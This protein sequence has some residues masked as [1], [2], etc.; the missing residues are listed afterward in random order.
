MLTCIMCILFLVNFISL[1]SFR[2]AYSLFIAL[3]P[4]TH[5]ISFFKTCQVFFIVIVAYAYL[6]KYVYNLQSAFSFVHIYICLGMATWDWTN[7]WE[8]MTGGD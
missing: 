1:E 7:M 8:L 2:H 3:P 5:S 4:S 6:Y